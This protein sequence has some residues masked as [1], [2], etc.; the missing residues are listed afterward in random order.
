MPVVCF[1]VLVGLYEEP[2]KPNNALEYLF[3]K[4][5]EFCQ[6]VSI[7]HLFEHLNDESVLKPTGK[8]AQVVKA[9][10]KSRTRVIIL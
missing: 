1:S 10:N 2:E 4:L 6:N 5:N 3:H 7:F 8:P 9:L